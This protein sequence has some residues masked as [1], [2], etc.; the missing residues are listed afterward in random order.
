MKQFIA[1]A[2]Q[3]IHIKKPLV[4][5]ITNYVTVN[6]CANITLAIGGSP[7][8]A[9]DANEVMD[10]TALSNALIINI[11]TLTE[12]TVESMLLAG[13]K[14]NQQNIPVILDPV[15]VGASH[16]RNKV[17]EELMKQIRFSV[18]KGNASEIRFLAGGNSRSNGVDAASEDTQKKEET[19]QLAQSLAHKAQCVIA[20]TGATDIVTDGE[21]VVLLENGCPEM[22]LIT[23]TGCMSTSL[24]AVFC[25][26][27]GEQI[28]HSTATALLSMGIAGEFAYK[29]TKLIGT[30]SF[31]LAII[32]EIS[33]LNEKKLVTYGKF[34][35]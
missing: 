29:K 34:Y 26:S 35:E 3:N 20:V 25:A 1:S 11:G 27:H 10:I 17:V 4:H 7:I 14:A 12:R 30:S 16:F 23:G 13:K 24:I 19:Q 2:I 31:R 33:Q 8:M 5:H 18:I 21:K 9:D 28:L 6:D 32:D 15:G 22:G